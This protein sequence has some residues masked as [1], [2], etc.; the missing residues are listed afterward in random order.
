M[1]GFRNIVVDGRPWKYRIGRGTVVA[2]SDDD[3]FETRKI[4]F[5]TLTG[6][7]WNSV[8]NMVHNRGFRITPRII[9]NWL[10]K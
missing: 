10:R 1:K 3:K 7:D 6:I 9:A 8:E 5:S 4:D 2:R